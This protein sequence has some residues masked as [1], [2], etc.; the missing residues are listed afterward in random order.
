MEEQLAVPGADPQGSLEGLTIIYGLLCFTQKDIFLLRTQ[1][2][3]F[4][5][6]V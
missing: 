2:E 4:Y 6:I 5:V 3:N 1:S